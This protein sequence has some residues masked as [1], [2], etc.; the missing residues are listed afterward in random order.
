MPCTCPNKW[1][2]PLEYQCVACVAGG[3]WRLSGEELETSNLKPQ[4]LVSYYTHYLF[5]LNNKLAG[6]RCFKIFWQESGI[7]THITF[8]IFMKEIEHIICSFHGIKYLWSTEILKEYEFLRVSQK[9]FSYMYKGLVSQIRMV[10]AYIV[11]DVLP[12]GKLLGAK[13]TIIFLSLGKIVRN[14]KEKT[15]SFSP[16]WFPHPVINMYCVCCVDHY[17]DNY[18]CWTHHICQDR[19]Q[20][21]TRCLVGVLD[22]PW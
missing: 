13:C 11:W 10:S 5:W 6:V 9:K 22:L 14:W 12:T 17:I 7:F 3:S 2:T 16:E 19:W 20:I 15:A 8:I 18:F 4:F 21:I 1:H